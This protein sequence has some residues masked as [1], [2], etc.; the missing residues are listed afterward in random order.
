MTGNI[1]NDRAM[2]TIVALFLVSA[3]LVVSSGQELRVDA[4]SKAIRAQAGDHANA[5][6]T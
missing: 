6:T 2:K 1:S 5:M 3:A 4:K